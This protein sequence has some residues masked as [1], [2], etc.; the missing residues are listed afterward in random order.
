MGTS[1]ITWLYSRVISHLPGYEPVIGSR[2]H[3]K[4]VCPIKHAHLTPHPLRAIELETTS[5]LDPS[6]LHLEGQQSSLLLTN[7]RSHILET[8]SQTQTLHGTSV[9]T[10]IIILE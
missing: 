6:G 2:L 1:T 4:G 5:A 3:V 8:I 10:N 7:V 9:F